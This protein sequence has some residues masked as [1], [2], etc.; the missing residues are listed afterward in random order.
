L[1]NERR[2]FFPPDSIV[3]QVRAALE[4]HEPGE[5]DYVTLVGQGEPLL[6]AS[7]GRLIREIRALSDVP[8]AVITNGSLLYM[9]EVR[10]ELAAA[11]VVM[12]TLDAVDEVSFREINRPWPK[13]HIR[14][15]IEGMIAFRDIFDGQLW[16]EVM[17]VKDLNDG[18]G[19]LLPLRD[20]LAWIQPDRI[21]INVPVRPPAEPWVQIPDEGAV[22]RAIAVLGEAAEAIGPYE[23]SFDLSG[24]SDISEAVET[25]VRRH[26]M[27]ERRLVETLSHHLR[28]SQGDVSPVQ[29]EAMLAQMES[30]GRIRRHTYRGAVFWGYAGR[31]FGE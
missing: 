11:H 21:Q 20:A 26:P 15:I 22:L 19:K 8:V 30:G 28:T 9:T 16:V 23:G 4:A 18:E 25:I 14:D 2:D 27:R 5:I 1:T 29:I 13:L 3:D 12:P 7:L 24:C 10:E 31:R 6:Y 17:L